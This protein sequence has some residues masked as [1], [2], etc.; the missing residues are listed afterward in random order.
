[1]STIKINPIGIPKN[2]PSNLSNTPPCPGKKLPVSLI[3]PFLF[4]NEKNKSPIW[5]AKEV[6][7]AIIIILKLLSLT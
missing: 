2:I 4:K 5:H 3:F 6:S 7:I 1:M